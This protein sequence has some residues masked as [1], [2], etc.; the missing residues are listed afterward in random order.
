MAETT[1]AREMFTLTK[2]GQQIGEG[3]ETELATL[4][5]SAG[6]VTTLMMQKSDAFKNTHFDSKKQI[7][8]EAVFRPHH[9]NNDDEEDARGA[10]ECVTRVTAVLTRA[11]RPARLD[12]PHCPPRAATCMRWASAP[13]A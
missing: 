11:Q 9:N 2:G 8:V 5:M 3:D 1:Y 4:G 10:G 6:K 12:S 7:S 13:R